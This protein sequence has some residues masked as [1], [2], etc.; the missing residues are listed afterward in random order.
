MTNKEIIIFSVTTVLVGAGAFVAGYLIGKHK[1]KKET[2]EIISQ[3]NDEINEYVEQITSGKIA[4]DMASSETKTIDYTQTE[5]YKKAKDLAK[6][7]EELKKEYYEKL[8][9]EGYASETREEKKDEEVDYEKDPEEEERRARNEELGYEDDEHYN[10]RHAEETD[11]VADVAVHSD[12]P[13]Y[14]IDEDDYFS[15]QFDAFSKQQFTYFGDGTL[16]DDCDE[17]I[18]NA[19]EVVGLDNLIELE[20]C[21]D[22]VIYV[23]NEPF[24]AD[25]E[26]VYKEMSYK[27]F[28][29]DID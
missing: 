16:I 23:R 14:M 2:D 1:M 28:M 18:P 4:D 12:L 25:Y 6:K 29:G 22:K 20:N 24:A 13:P 9:Q 27:E 3:M 19:E 5:K 21:E 11:I 7:N 10:A 26:V 8:K 17:I 15:G